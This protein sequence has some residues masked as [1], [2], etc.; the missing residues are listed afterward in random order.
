MLEDFKS[1]PEGSIF[2]LHACAHNPTG[3]DPTR[4]DWKELA[5]VMKAK[6]HFPWFDSAY[7]GFA[8][9]NVD[10]DA[11]AVRYFVEQG[12]DVMVFFDSPLSLQCPA[13]SDCTASR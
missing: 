13:T 8:T 3:V 6:K 7:Q 9:G 10:G 4:E 5:A 11:W 1:A 2:L 12:F